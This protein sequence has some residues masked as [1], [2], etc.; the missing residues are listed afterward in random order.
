M[1]DE[2]QRYLSHIV[3]FMKDH[4]RWWGEQDK[5]FVASTGDKRL[6]A[7]ILGIYIYFKL[8]FVLLTVKLH[9]TT[10]VIIWKADE[11]FFFVSEMFTGYPA[12]VLFH[13]SDHVC[14][15]VVFNEK[16]NCRGCSFSVRCRCKT[17]RRDRAISVFRFLRLSVP[18]CVK[19]TSLGS[20]FFYRRIIVRNRYINVSSRDHKS[21]FLSS[22]RQI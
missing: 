9:R 6:F 2:S 7:I 11:I 10:A 8:T 3:Y 12:S 19:A 22:I 17:H 5:I 15:A 21:I 4:F 20:I 18:L 16:N 14:L 1:D 13:D